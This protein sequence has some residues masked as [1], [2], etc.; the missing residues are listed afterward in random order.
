VVA[1]SVRRVGGGCT[2][3]VQR[4]SKD[5]VARDDDAVMSWA[6]SASRVV[7]FPSRG[8]D[9]FTKMELT[10][11]SGEDDDGVGD[12]NVKADEATSTQGITEHPM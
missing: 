12:A 11:P 6:S 7:T 1:E 4:K 10:P 9:S 3:S 5:V 2:P 8:N